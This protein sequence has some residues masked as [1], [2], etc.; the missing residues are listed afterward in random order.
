MLYVFYSFY[1]LSLCVR[2]M[3]CTHCAVCSKYNV[4]RHSLCLIRLTRGFQHRDQVM[5]IVHFNDVIMSAMAS[6]ITSLT[7]V[8]ST[9]YSRRR[10]KKASKLRV[11]GLCVGNSPVTGEFPAQRASNAENVSI[12]WRHHGM[13]E[14]FVV[15]IKLPFI[16]QWRLCGSRDCVINFQALLCCHVEARLVCTDQLWSWLLLQDVLAPT[17]RQACSDPNADSAVTGVLSKSY[18]TTCISGYSH[19]NHYMM[20]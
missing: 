20:A 14:R 13:T 17:W 7:I 11:T 9:V 4:K 10:P 12:W 19:Q 6:Q 8:Y 18:H 3:L 5:R 15:V 1:L 2:S 16:F